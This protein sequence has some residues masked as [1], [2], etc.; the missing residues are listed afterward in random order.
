VKN[1]NKLE[2]FLNEQVSSA[3]PTAT[4]FC[5]KPRSLIHFMLSQVALYLE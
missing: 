4:E 2:A 5:S 1:A 3:P